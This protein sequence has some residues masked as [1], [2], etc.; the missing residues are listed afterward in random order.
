M[1]FL[2]KEN[3]FPVILRFSKYLKRHCIYL[4]ET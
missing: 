1:T 2:G 3:D 4:G